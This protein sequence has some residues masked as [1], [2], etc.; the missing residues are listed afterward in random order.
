MRNEQEKCRDTYRTGSTIPPKSHQGII[1][2]LL[3]LV[4]VLSSIVAILGM[5]NIRLWSLLKNQKDPQ[6]ENPQQE[7]IALA[8][9]ADD[10]LPSAESSSILGMTCQEI[11]QLYRSYN[12]WPNGLYISYVEPGSAADQGEILPG[13]ILISV[14]G[15]AVTSWDALEK[16]VQTLSAGDLLKLTVYRN[17]KQMEIVLTIE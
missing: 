12:D 14:N 9:F 5:M 1:A 17:E 16:T 15:A 13:D 7:H 4:T 11:S 3:I 8:E 6:L 10:A 2:A